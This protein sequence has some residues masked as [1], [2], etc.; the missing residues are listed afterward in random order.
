M[1]INTLYCPLS[2]HHEKIDFRDL[3]HVISNNWKRLPPDE[4]VP[5]GK[6]AAFRTRQWE[7][8]EKPTTIWEKHSKETVTPSPANTPVWVE[9][10]DDYEDNDDK[11]V[12]EVVTDV[13]AQI[14]ASDGNTVVKKDSNPPPPPPAFWPLSGKSTPIAD[15]IRNF[16]YPQHTLM[17]THTC[18]PCAM[19]AANHK[20]CDYTNS[21][22]TVLANSLEQDGRDF[23]L[24]ALLDDGSESASDDEATDM[25]E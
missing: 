17:H 10:D 20:C 18:L 7:K 23:F 15:Y 11:I 5:Y 9:D 12:E 19:V 3:A 14:E 4:K 24:Q 16:R 1:T 6:L 25:V 21:E 13:M 22:V 2:S 8:E